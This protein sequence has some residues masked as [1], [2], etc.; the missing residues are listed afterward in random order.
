MDM[1]LN[2]PAIASD[3][4]IMILII[5]MRSY[6]K[7]C[8]LWD[9]DINVCILQK[10]GMDGDGFYIDSASS[11]GRRIVEWR[12]NAILLARSRFL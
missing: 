5:I 8:G 7:K 2:G 6:I 1:T 4:A 11:A 12:A 10:V 9:K 3:I